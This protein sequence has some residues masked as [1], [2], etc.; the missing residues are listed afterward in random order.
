MQVE[1]VSEFIAERM[2]PEAVIERSI[3]GTDDPERIWERVLEVCPDAVE[4]FAFEVSAARSSGCGF[5]TAP[6]WR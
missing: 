4:C 2:W 6:G 3:F 1:G 5:A